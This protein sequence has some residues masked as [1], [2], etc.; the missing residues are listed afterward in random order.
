LSLFFYIIF[1]LLYFTLETYTFKINCF[2]F[3]V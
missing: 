3:F 2:Y 1:R